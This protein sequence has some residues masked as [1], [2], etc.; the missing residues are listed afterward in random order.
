MCASGGRAAAKRLRKPK[1]YLRYGA[2]LRGAGV[3][4]LC[5]IGLSRPCGDPRCDLRPLRKSL[6]TRN[7]LAWW[8]DL[9][10]LRQDAERLA[11]TP[12]WSFLERGNWQ[13]RSNA[14]WGV[15]SWDY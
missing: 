5:L 1:D 3:A 9:R 4:H 13:D 8:A 14:S 10:L 11:G 7:L 6:P 2:R 12:P 15:A